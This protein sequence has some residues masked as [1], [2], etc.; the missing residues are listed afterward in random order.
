MKPLFHSRCKKGWSQNAH[1]TVHYVAHSS[2]WLNAQPPILAHPAIPRHRTALATSLVPRIHRRIRLHRLLI[3]ASHYVALRRAEHASSALGVRRTAVPESTV[4]RL[5]CV[6]ETL[7]ISNSKDLDN[8]V[9]AH[10]RSA[11]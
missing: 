5:T 4:Q 9:A 10:H 7:G 8:L 2:A 1:L 3:T 6:Q 11:L